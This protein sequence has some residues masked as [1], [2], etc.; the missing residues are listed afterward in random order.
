LR[1]TSRILSN[2]GDFASIQLCDFPDVPFSCPSWAS[3]GGRGHRARDRIAAAVRTGTETRRLRRPDGDRRADPQ[4]A[5]VNGPH[6]RRRFLSC[7]RT[8]GPV[9]GQC[10]LTVAVKSPF[11]NITGFELDRLNHSPGHCADLRDEPQARRRESASRFAAIAKSTALVRRP[12]VRA[13]PRVAAGH[14][15]GCNESLPRPG[16]APAP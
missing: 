9:A 2:F 1:N 8:A 11:V 14:G 4:P 6:R 16:P 12:Q 5:R 3:C 7:R 10:R 13:D 15:D